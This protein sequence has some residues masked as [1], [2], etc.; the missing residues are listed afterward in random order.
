MAYENIEKLSDLLKD[1]QTAALKKAVAASEKRLGDLMKKLADIEAAAAQA[2][3]EEEARVREEAR[4]KEEAER[5]A[6]EAEKQ[7]KSR[8]RNEG[9]RTAS[10]GSESGR[11]K[12]PRA[13]AVPRYQSANGGKTCKAVTKRLPPCGARRGASHVPPRP[14]RGASSLSGRREPAAAVRR[15]TAVRRPS[16][17]AGC[18]SR[19]GQARGRSKTASASSRTD[20]APR[21]AQKIRK[22]VCGAAP[23]Q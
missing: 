22:N 23:R 21:Y 10:G 18:A 8:R 2:R 14:S 20:A 7:K 1:G 15:K 12:I 6:E 19:N 11:R 17:G 5:A 4:K 9:I 16:A 13:F 3:A